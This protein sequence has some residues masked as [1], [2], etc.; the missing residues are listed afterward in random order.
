MGER[1]QTYAA[2]NAS[3]IK[4]DID[5]ADWPQSV[6]VLNSTLIEEQNAQTLTDVLTN[7][8][9]VVASQDQEQV[10]VNPFIRG[11][12]S[13]IY[14][15]GLIAYG[16]T[17]VIDPSSLAVV[18]RIEVAKGAN[19][20]L[21]GGGTGAPTGGLINLVT[22][23]PL[24]DSHYE[25]VLKGGSH[26]TRAIQAD[27]NQPVSDALLLRLAGEWYESDDTIDAVEVKRRT[28]NP[29]AGWDISASTRLLVRGFYNQ[30]EQLEYTGLP[31]Q[32]ADI[33][34]VRPDQFSGA[35]NAPFTEIEN[36]A[37][38]ISLDHSLSDDLSMTLQ[39]RY[40]A[41]RFDEFSSFPFLSFFPIA[42]TSAPI[43]RGRL[44]V[45]T[46]EI[47]LDAA[48]QYN[49]DLGARGVHALLVGVTWDNT[50]YEAGSGFDFTPIGVLDY[51]SPANTL[52]F[53][54]VPAINQMVE[55][56]YQTL[57]VYV[58]D[59]ITIAANWRL[60]LSGRYS[61][62]SLDEVLGG[63]GADETYS[64][65]DPRIGLTYKLS[66]T[67]SIFAGYATGSR[68]V[69]FFTGVNSR[70]PVPEE[71]ESYELGLKFAGGTLSGTLALFRLERDHIPQTD[72]TDPFFGSVQNGRQKSEGAELDLIWEPN[73]DISVLASAAYVDAVNQTDIASFGTLF[74][75][76]NELSRVPR[77]SAR[78]AG[79]YRFSAGVLRG[80]GVGIGM[81]YAD[82][83]PLTDANVFYSDP[84]TVF[85]LQADYRINRFN[86]RLNVVNLT[87]KEY[88]KPWQYLLQEVVRQGQ[89]RSVYFSVGVEI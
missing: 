13:E 15:D 75:A 66:D 67:L 54:T 47:T 6:Q 40:F 89:E 21:Y 79:R 84:Y 18:E 22:K 2:D 10:L 12:E 78:L 29:S 81:T 87:D 71:S 3:V 14:L 16:D 72:L 76:G 68:V 74:P 46:D 52:D 88:F 32:V 33:A 23:S 8:S 48:F 45:D 28:I 51:A 30:I 37:L 69:P 43:I 50:E 24:P 19:S 25:F 82:E 5:L 7:V 58:Q 59:H 35:V 56:E 53:G 62:Y 17:A 41:N 80:L 83:A 20:V 49:M 44:P 38:H 1:L 64:E 55:N 86:L 85:D 11:L 9:S 61:R 4:A 34:G 73:P 57:A 77:R 63:T 31:A 60:L 70:P 27:L 36:K 26:S 39:A 65:F 42:G